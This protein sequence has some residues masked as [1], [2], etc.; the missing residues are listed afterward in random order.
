[1]ARPTYNDEYLEVMLP[2][3]I[4]GAGRRVADGDVE[5]LRP[6]AQ[7]H[8]AI[9]KATEVA[10]AG[11]LRAGYSWTDIARPLGVSRQYAWR[12]YK[13]LQQREEQTT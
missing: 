10:V 13:H 12:A 4:R 6:L 8:A 2:R 5:A 7:L 1:M 11:L 9:D 3:L